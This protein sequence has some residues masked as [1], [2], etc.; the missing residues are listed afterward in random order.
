MS[1]KDTS[2]TAICYTVDPRVEDDV[3]L[4]AADT[5]LEVGPERSDQPL[6]SISQ[7]D[8]WAGE[9]PLDSIIA[10]PRYW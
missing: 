4:I 9:A 2:S 8:H 5:S 1:L 10:F 6:Q 3:E 7:T